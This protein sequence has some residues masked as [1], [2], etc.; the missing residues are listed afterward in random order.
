MQRGSHESKMA[1]CA[2]Q[3]RSLFLEVQCGTSEATTAVFLPF[4]DGADTLRL[5][6]L[7]TYF[8]KLVDFADDHWMR[9]LKLEF[10][11]LRFDYAGAEAFLKAIRRGER[12]SKNRRRLDKVEIDLEPPLA[13]LIES[14]KGI[15]GINRMLYARTIRGV[16]EQMCNIIQGDICHSQLIFLRT[17]FS[18]ENTTNPRTCSVMPANNY[19]VS[20]VHHRVC[21]Y[22]NFAD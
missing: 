14:D 4:L 6:S 18:T 3:R 8:R 5:R 20:S 17:M 15:L 7:G 10:G 13:L 11:Q 1:A 12:L 2:G 19:F 9:I 21:P 22:I 16:F